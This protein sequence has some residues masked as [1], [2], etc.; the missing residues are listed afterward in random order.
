M[1]H[2][3]NGRNGHDDEKRAEREAER[4]FE[5]SMRASDAKDVQYW[6]DREAKDMAA[7]D[8]VRMSVEEAKQRIESRHQR[9]GRPSYLTKLTT[10]PEYTGER[11]LCRKKLEAVRS[12]LEYRPIIA[13]KIAKDWAERKAG[14]LWCDIGKRYGLTGNEALTQYESWQARLSGALDPSSR[15][16]FPISKP[17][18]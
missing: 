9:E 14:T 8:D 11:D 18:P 12:A 13:S 17:S 6:E 3:M 15:Y 16:C 5:E 4:Q 1:I 10:P 7:L 2:P